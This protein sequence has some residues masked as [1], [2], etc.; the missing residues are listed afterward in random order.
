M[1][2]RLLALIGLIVLSLTTVAARPVQAP[3][4]TYH[5]YDVHITLADDGNFLVRETYVLRFDDT[6]SEGFAEIP[7]AYTE[8]VE[9]LGF[10]EDDTPYVLNG[11]GP[12]SYTI[13]Q[14]TEA[15][16]LEWSYTPTTAGEE[17]TFSVEYR[18]RGGL[19]VYDDAQILRWRAVP[20][21]R[22]GIP[23]ETSEIIVE[24]PPFINPQDV[25][26]LSG[27]APADVRYDGQRIVYTVGPIPDGTHLQIELTFP[28]KS[29]PVTPAGW[30][31]QEDARALDYRVE[32]MLVTLTIEPDGSVVVEERQTINVL[33]GVLYGMS[34]NISH[35]FVDS[36]EV[37]GVAEGD[38]AF[39]LTTSPCEGCYQV[40]TSPTQPGWVTYNQ[41]SKKI[42]YNDYAMGETRVS[43]DF[44]PLREQRTTFT[45]RYRL[46]GVLRLTPD[47]QSLTWQA[48]PGGRDES[49]DM[50]QARVVL[51]PGIAATQVQVKGGEVTSAADGSLL[52]T[53]GPLSGQEPWDV[54]LT[55]PPNATSATKAAWQQEVERLEIEAQKARQRQAILQI[56]TVVGSFLLFVG[57]AGGAFLAWYLWGR[58]V[59]VGAVADVLP[60]PPSE[61]PP[62]IVAYLLKE[63][64][65][66][67]GALATLFH[68]GSLGLLTISFKGKDLFLQRTYNGPLTPGTPIQLNEQETVVVTPHMA[69]LFNALL[70]VIPLEGTTL[71]LIYGQFLAILPK[72]YEAM[73]Q[74]ADAFFAERPEKVRGNWRSIG[75]LVLLGGL[76]LLCVGISLLGRDVGSLACFPGLAVIGG[77][78]GIF[79]I[80]RWMPR[81]TSAGALEAA[82]WRAFQRFLQDLKKHADL[83]NA[84]YML[85]RYFAYAVALDVE[86]VVIRHAAELGARPPLWMQPTIIEVRDNRIYPRRALWRT[87]ELAGATGAATVL[88]EASAPSASKTMPDFS[89]QTMSDQL[90]S[91]INNASSGL[92]TVLTDATRT[93]GAPS[94][95][96]ELDR[97]LRTASGGGSSSYRSSSRT[98]WSS[99]SSSRRSWSSGSSRSSGGFS[100]SRSSSRSSSSSRSGGGGRR[101]FR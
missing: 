33:S 63:E 67:K 43:W 97:I 57:T 40:E 26:A 94:T 39:Q 5:R 68:L 73:A 49:I 9:I 75:V 42:E 7:T 60:R 74:E 31:R 51:P 76:A 6:F 45:L 93:P 70:S 36:V 55:L 64:A 14:E 58:D 101:G 34:R 79:I 87:A 85:D 11:S 91:A 8:N 65:T 28:P 38:L 1:T 4:I 15:L 96:A 62:G 84:Q 81:R 10:Y 61:L 21:D 89:L 71:S 72:V 13:T 78:V 12:G 48:V 98:S 18:V 22:S 82:K 27:G 23:V 44:P 83:P 77:S 86:D 37:L 30:Q 88:R 41:W 3:A 56:I 59:Q 29:F 53:H 19:W 2:R 17:R 50:A 54:S 32:Q 99:A 90:I 47:A 52:I 24:L 35:R 16:Y 100:S 69:T 80:A 25:L 95:Q 46:R 20:A 92:A 66:V